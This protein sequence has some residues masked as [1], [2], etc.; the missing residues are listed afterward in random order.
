MSR[1]DPNKEYLFLPYKRKNIKGELTKYEVMVERNELL[2]HINYLFM[3]EFNL[4]YQ[5]FEKLINE[6]FLIFNDADELIA[7]YKEDLLEMCTEEI[8]EDH[9]E[10]LEEERWYYDMDD[11]D[12]EYYDE[13]RDRWEH[14]VTESMFH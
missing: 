3:Q 1:Y 8:E 12:E 14:G 10:Q 7:R 5:S 2:G 4:S 9:K 6:G 13:A 11:E